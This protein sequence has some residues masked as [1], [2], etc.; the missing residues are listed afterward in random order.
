MKDFS[1]LL[2]H[3]NLGLAQYLI[4]CFKSLQIPIEQDIILWVAVPGAAKFFIAVNDV[5]YETWS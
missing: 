2:K 5:I 4:Y 1:L 3:L